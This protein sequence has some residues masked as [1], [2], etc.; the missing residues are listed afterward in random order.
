MLLNFPTIQC[1][2]PKTTDSKLNG[3]SCPDPLKTDNE[4]FPTMRQPSFE[5]EGGRVLG[6]L[7]RLCVEEPCLP[8]NRCFSCVHV[9]IDVSRLSSEANPEQEKCMK[10]QIVVSQSPSWNRASLHSEHVSIRRLRGAVYKLL[11]YFDIFCY[12]NPW[13]KRLLGVSKVSLVTAHTHKKKFV[14]EQGRRI[15]VY[16]F[17]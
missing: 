1:R 9:S 16:E 6:Y 12:R 4:R 3:L 11:W 8:R 2:S 17:A 5:Q 13:S 14:F 10:I 15:S 7:D